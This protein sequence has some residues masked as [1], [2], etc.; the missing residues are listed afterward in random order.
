MKKKTITLFAILLLLLCFTSCKSNDYERREDSSN[1][2]YVG[3]VDS[4]FPTSFMPWLSREGIAPTIASMLYNTLF[5]F[6]DQTGDFIPLIANDWYYVDE[7]GNPIVNDDNTID[8]DSLE[9][10]YGDNNQDYLVV[11]I[12]LHDNVFWSD[13]EQLTVEDIYYTYD[14]ACNNILSNHAGALAWTAD[15]QHEYK[16]GILTKQ[17]IFTYEHGANEKGYSI[18]ESDKDTVMFIHVNKVLGAITSL[19]ST[20]LILPEHI[21]AP[22]VTVSNQL[23]SKCPTEESLYAY[24]NPVGSGPYILDSENSNSQVIT[25]IRNDT[26]HL[27]DN[28]DYLYKVEK[29]KFLLY[30]ESNV[31]IYSLLKGHIDILDS[32]ISSNYMSL[33]LDRDD[34]FVANA[35]GTFTQ[36]LVMNVNPAAAEQNEFR[37]LFGNIEFRRAIAL[38]VDQE[39]LISSVLNDAGNTISAGLMTES[40][41]DFYNP[42]ADILSGELNTKLIEA[43]NI[44]D[45]ICPNKDKD[46]YRTLNGNR[47]SYEILGSATEQEIISRLQ[48]Q[49]QKIGI[50][51]SYK[52]KGSAPERTY[53]FNSKFD[54]T[55][56]YVIFSLSN[57][58]IMYKAHFVTLSNSSNYG[59][60]NDP[61]LSAKIDEMRASLNLNYKYQLMEELQLMIAEEYYKIPLYTSNVISVAR[62]D[63]FIGYQVQ[64]GETVFNMETLKHL[65]KVEVQ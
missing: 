9:N 55:L 31:A 63:R 17:G 20:I 24:Q 33:F 54:M 13:G 22:V 45:E 18:D 34:V 58:D 40:L 61:L 25:L 12:V 23:N 41:E 28:D 3:A 51:V 32:T 5:K 57:V 50:E 44:L 64:E 52:T 11:K 48:I 4:S 7:L 53:I 47:I 65:E 10:I 36:T 29:I 21:W 2:L 60:L 59:R 46:G 19:F 49:L 27:T 30:Q 56:H 43:N 37:E 6:D 16:N 15:L 8:Y 38:A 42:E 62:T 39:E 26:Y 35:P 1:T 14:I